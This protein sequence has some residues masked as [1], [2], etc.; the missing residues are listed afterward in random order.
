MN[1]ELTA[2][3]VAPIELPPAPEPDPNVDPIA[4]AVAAELVERGYEGATVAGVVRRAGVPAAEFERRFD[5]LEACVLDAYERFIADFQ[6][7]VGGA[8]NRQLNWPSALRSAAYETAD[9]MEENPHLV[10]FGTAEVL[11]MPGEMFRVRREEVF[12]FCAELIDRGREASRDPEAIPEVAPTF[13]IGAILQL[14]TVRLQEGAPIDP[15][16][17][18]P[19]M[20]NRIVGIYLGAEAADAEWSALPLSSQLRV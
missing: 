3:S 8:F 5:G 4:T 9:W 14:L 1:R 6:R 7:R 19:E 11:K 17:V 13:A 10:A 2:R 20:M 16:R 18:I 15:R 12:D